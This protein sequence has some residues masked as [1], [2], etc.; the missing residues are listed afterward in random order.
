MALDHFC[1]TVSLAMPLVVL[2]SVWSGVAGCGWLSLSKAVCIGQIACAFRNSA[3]NSASVALD[4]MDFMIWHKMWTGPLL[5]GG[6]SCADGGVEGHVLRKQYPAAWDLF[7]CR[8]VGC[9]AMHPKDHVTCGIADN[10]MWMH[11]VIIE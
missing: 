9:I 5:G 10:G 1:F 11:G 7:W 4:M 8:K 3:P 2:L 6:S